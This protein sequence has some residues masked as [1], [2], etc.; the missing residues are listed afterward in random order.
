M[1]LITAWICTFRN[2]E[3]G[4]S[5]SSADNANWAISTY[6]RYSTANYMNVFIICMFCL[7]SFFSSVDIFLVCMWLL[8]CKNPSHFNRWL[9]WNDIIYFS[10]SINQLLLTTDNNLNNNSFNL[11]EWTTAILY[12]T[13]FW[14]FCF[15]SS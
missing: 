2:N 6:G 13:Y 5:Q 12:R 10:E 11:T 4:I 1:S 15:N 8:F 14:L 7:H 3:C 9:R